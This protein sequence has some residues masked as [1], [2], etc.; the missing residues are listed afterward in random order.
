MEEPKFSFS[1][2]VKSFAKL[3]AN[4]TAEKQMAQLDE[5]I[6]DQVDLQL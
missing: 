1:Q 6:V 3:S 2:A 5:I 4:F